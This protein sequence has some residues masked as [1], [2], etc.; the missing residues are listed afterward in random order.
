MKITIVGTVAVVRTGI[1]YKEFLSAQRFDS[2]CCVLTNEKGEEYF[3]VNSPGNGLD[4]YGA[5]LAAGVEGEMCITLPVP[6]DTLAAAKE[7]LLTRYAVPLTNLDRVITQIK[8]KLPELTAME[9]RIGDMF[10]NVPEP[11]AAE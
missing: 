7:N 1:T 10:E 3:N 9:E 6:C 11:T 2:S 4:T 5:N 8:E